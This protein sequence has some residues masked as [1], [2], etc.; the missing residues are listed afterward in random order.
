[1]AAGGLE[2][3]KRDPWWHSRWDERLLFAPLSTLSPHLRRLVLVLAA[4]AA[5]AWSSLYNGNL[6]SVWQLP[7]VHFYVLLAQGRYDLVPQPFTARP[8]APLLARGIAAALHCWTEGGFQVLAFLCLLWTEGVLFWLMV[9]TE[10]PRWMLLAV[11]AVPFWPQLLSDA[12]LPDPLYA[13]LLSCLLLA[14]AHKRL[15]VAA[16]LMLPLM[17]ARESTS[18]ML[19]CL[20]AVGWRRLRWTG[21]AVAVGGTALGAWL[22]HR[23]SAG[24]LPNPEH[25]S[26]S[27]YMAGKLFSNTLRSLGVRPWSNVYPAL[28]PTPA[29]QMPLHLGAVQAIG[30][31]SWSPDLLLLAWWAV[32][33]VFGALPL[34]LL[35]AQP[36]FR[37]G[38]RSLFGHPSTRAGAREGD[39]VL[40]FSVLYGGVSLLLGPIL[41]LS[42]ARLVGYG[43]PLLLVGL[44]RLWARA[45]LGANGRM[46]AT[47]NRAWEGTLLIAHLLVCAVGLM[48]AS[49][50]RLLTVVCLETFMLSLLVVRRRGAME[51]CRGAVESRTRT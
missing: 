27:V 45:D 29:W 28:C 6:M 9:R 10:A 8:L 30:I 31:C 11:A 4:G 12:G 2:Q 13:A 33:T 21:C 15:W 37:G 51:R 7:D 36:S 16:A 18:L 50:G 44:P 41:G 34:L 25:L 38:I 43:W 26:G 49:P 32:L 14:L 1:M 40:R 42:Y 24:G 23:I 5:L 39:L 20:L 35:A 22:V 47:T 46:Q 48:I 19:I 3:V 17:L